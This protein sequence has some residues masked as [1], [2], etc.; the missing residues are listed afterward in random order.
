[1]TRRAL[2]IKHSSSRDDR[3]A[4]LLADR[5]LTIDWCC[6]S[7]GDRL[8]VTTAGHTLL[9]VYGGAQSANDGE[10]RG[11]I[12][13]ETDF[14]SRWVEQD[15]P[16]LGLCLGAQML[17]RALGARVEP[18][19]KGLQEVGYFAI[20][21]TP[22]GREM[23]PP[24]MFV[25]HWHKEGFELPDG[26]CLLA[27]GERFRNQ[28][29]RYGKR[30]LAVQFHPEVTLEM[31]SSWADQPEYIRADL[32][33]HSRERQLADAERFDAIIGAWCE[34]FVDRQVMPLLEDEPTAAD[35]GLVAS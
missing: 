21:P 31:V 11:C 22:A 3:V 30:A 27:T 1:M 20:E 8:P 15:R 18:H 26:A 9:V 19:P 34:R 33:A 29:F 12:R 25:Y 4:R 17:A 35:A 23:F 5:G 6:P 32:G 24:Q 14:L 13:D 16:F 10:A 2:L 7:D 28:A